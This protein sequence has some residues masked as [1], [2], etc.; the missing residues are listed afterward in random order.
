MRFIGDKLANY[1]VDIVVRNDLP[2]A[3]DFKNFASE[4]RNPLLPFPDKWIAGFELNRPGIAGGNFCELRGY[5][6]QVQ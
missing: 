1:G 5:G 2:F 6:L 3:F 4:F